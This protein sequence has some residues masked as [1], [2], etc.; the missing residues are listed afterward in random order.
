MNITSNIL[1]IHLTKIE[2]IIIYIDRKLIKSREECK[3]LALLTRTQQK[4]SKITGAAR[5][6]FANSD[7]RYRKVSSNRYNKIL[8]AKRSSSNESGSASSGNE[9][10]VMR[11]ENRNLRKNSTGRISLSSAP[12][13]DNECIDSSEE[14]LNNRNET[15]KSIEDFSENYDWRLPKFVE[16][17]ET[18][19]QDLEK[20]PQGPKKEVLGE[21][22][23]KVEFL[24]KSRY[25]IR[26][27]KIRSGI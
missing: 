19:L 1:Y 10:S 7:R 3:F 9:N 21:Y 23:L 8:N 16:T 18:W 24:K 13:T 27:G 20:H 17:L 26:R 2:E 12:T 15:W 11:Q 5:K 25:H 22:R 14:Q 4:V 6:T